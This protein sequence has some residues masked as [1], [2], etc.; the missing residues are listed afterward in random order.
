[1]YGILLLKDHLKSLPTPTTVGGGGRGDGGGSN[2]TGGGGLKI[3]GHVV[4]QAGKQ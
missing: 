3:G 1:M 4:G 2:R